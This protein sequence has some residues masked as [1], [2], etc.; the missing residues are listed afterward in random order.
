MKIFGIGTDIVS[1]DR[2][3]K[4]V[5]NKRFLSRVYNIK[6][7]SKCKKLIKSDHCFAKHWETLRMRGWE[8][9]GQ[10]SQQKNTWEASGMSEQWG[11]GARLAR[12]PMNEKD[13]KFEWQNIA[14]ERLSIGEQWS[15]SSVKLQMKDSTD[16]GVLRS[17]ARPPILTKL[18]THP[19]VVGHC[20]P[21]H[22]RP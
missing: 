11:N 10:G 1:I 12:N 13:R 20:R 16:V 6:E 3:K 18:K 9:Q 19:A 8:W 22:C 17:H 21:M 2:I 4:S 5:K 15:G 7:I 14:N